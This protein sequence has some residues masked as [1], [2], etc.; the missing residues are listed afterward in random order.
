ML[1]NNS[2][3]LAIV[4]LEIP[5]LMLAWWS[6]RM[7][8]NAF[9]ATPGES[10]VHEDCGFSRHTGS[11]LF[12]AGVCPLG[13]VAA[14]ALFVWTL[15]FGTLLLTLSHGEKFDRNKK[16]LGWVHVSVVMAIFGPAFFMNIHLFA[17]SLPYLITQLGVVVL[18]LG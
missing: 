13:K 1:S 17:R 14:W 12:E 3:V 5:A 7:H 15:L 8:M 16:I 9:T 18:L 6:F 10:G 11:T 2:L 4:F